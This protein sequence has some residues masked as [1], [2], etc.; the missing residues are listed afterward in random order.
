MDKKIEEQ[1]KLMGFKLIADHPDYAGQKNFP[2][3]NVLE[4]E[5]KT[6]TNIGLNLVFILRIARVF[7]DESTG[8]M[9]FDVDIVKNVFKNEAPYQIFHFY[10]EKIS[11]TVEN[12]MDFVRESMEKA[13]KSLENLVMSM[14]E[15]RMLGM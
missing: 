5:K 13:G 8:I 1:L 6:E 7:L 2:L 4:F 11:L 10:T 9:V 15:F 14:N 12:V 3:H